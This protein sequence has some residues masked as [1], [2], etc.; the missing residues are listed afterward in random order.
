MYNA[1]SYEETRRMLTTAI[2][3]RSARAIT[4]KQLTGNGLVQKRCIETIL[5]TSKIPRTPV[6]LN[7]QVCD[8]RIQVGNRRYWSPL[9]RLNVVDCEVCDQPK[10][11]AA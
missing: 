1:R 9:S 10:R 7:R 8:L 6:I 5:V 4:Q 11:Y 3:A 2:E